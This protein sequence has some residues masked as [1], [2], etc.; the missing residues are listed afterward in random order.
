MLTEFLKDVI[1]IWHDC[2]LT[3]VRGGWVGGGVVG[4]I[5]DSQR[6]RQ[7][8]IRGGLCLG[9]GLDKQ[10]REKEDGDKRQS[11]GKGWNH[12]IDCHGDRQY[13]KRGRRVGRGDKDTEKPADKQ[14]RRWQALSDNP[15]HKDIKALTRKDSQ[16]QRP[17]IRCQ[18]Y[19][20]QN[21]VTQT[22]LQVMWVIGTIC[23]FFFFL[24]PSI[25]S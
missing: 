4:E 1:L 22:C 12:H 18:H 23:F 9:K 25:Y 16:M 21:K 8:I 6:K 7:K 13:R 24:T 3:G 17:G 14:V 20:Q 2:W 19:R 10:Q 11:A 5:R 15:T